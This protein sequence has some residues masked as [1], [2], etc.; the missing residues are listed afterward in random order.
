MTLAE[1]RLYALRAERRLE[2]QQMAEQALNE[3]RR[4]DD[5]IRGL[6]SDEESDDDELKRDDSDG[7]DERK[8]SD[9]AVYVGISTRSSSTSS[10][11]RNRKNKSRV[12]LNGAVVAMSRVDMDF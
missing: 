12:G 1:H 9:G 6:S 3:D 8:D 7:S 10:P 11:V 4:D 2:A 5:D